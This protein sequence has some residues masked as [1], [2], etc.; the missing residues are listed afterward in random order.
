M[1]D[2]KR[3]IYRGALAAFFAVMTLFTILS[4]IVD[5]RET[6]KVKLTYASRGSVTKTVRG[7]GAVEAGSE[8]GIRL[9][10]GLRIGEIA[11]L[12]GTVVKEGDLLFRYTQDSILERLEAIGREIR[13]LEIAIEQETIRAG[14][15]QGVTE[16]E[17]AEQAL[18]FAR[19]E[20]ERLSRKEREANAEYER[21]AKR[22]RSYYKKRLDLSEEELIRASY[23]D[24]AMSRTDYK[25][26][27][28]D[29]DSRIKEIERSIK[30]AETALAR[31]EKK[32]EKAQDKAE[33]DSGTD[34][35]EEALLQIEEEI[36]DWEE[37]REQLTEDLDDT[38]DSLDLKVERAR[39]EME[40]KED[41]YDRA[42]EEADSARL[43]LKE[44][45]ENGLR[46]EFSLVKAA[47]EA[48]EAA[49]RAVEAALLDLENARKNDR[50]RELS[51]EQAKRL[52]AL[53]NEERRLDLEDYMEEQAALTALLDA[54]GAVL[55]AA[56]GSVTAMELETGKVTDGSERFLLSSGDL[57]FT[58]SFDRETE[59]SVQAGEAIDITLVGET[60]PVSSVISRVDLVSDPV[61]GTLTA[62]LEGGTAA[63]GRKASFEVKRNG[64]IYNTVIPSAALRRDTEGW[65]CLAA[66][67]QK[68]ILG[69]EYR[70]VRI[71]LNLL[72]AG[73]VSAAVEGA[74]SAEEPVITESDRVIG[75]GD[76][77]RPMSELLE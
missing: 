59:G 49:D 18:G 16:A 71:D 39:E 21:Q 55:A 65:Y 60:Q 27:K 11:A 47:E 41:I 8:M 68:T 48:R 33:S 42:G 44:A 5:A 52:A 46:Q 14:S 64:E 9:T 63:L 3:R 40:E 28:L 25:S 37:R 72:L 13:R 10:P 70:A 4:R 57:R 22:L 19:K 30:E 38:K 36:E 69:E 53:A 17:A 12:P 23:G 1:E 34:A 15:F 74:L 2:K 45:Y 29:R 62:P 24:Y 61:T 75:A 50:A 7:N 66:R 35:D 26:A 51:A 43:A 54:G 77:V 6:A 73:D 76:R 20:Q 67:R 31:L 32:R 58:G 56:S